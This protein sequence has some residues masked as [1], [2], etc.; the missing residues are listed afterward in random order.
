ML[1]ISPCSKHFPMHKSEAVTCLDVKITATVLGFPPVAFWTRS[2]IKSMV[3]IFPKEYEV[4]VIC[5]TT[6]TLILGLLLDLLI[7]KDW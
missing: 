1:P 5:L 3:M 2:L 4:S 7:A 6:F